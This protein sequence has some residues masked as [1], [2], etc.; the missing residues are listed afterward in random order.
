MPP[1]RL[2]IWPDRFWFST[3]SL[4]TGPSRR[5][6]VTILYALS[7]RAIR[8]ECSN[9]TRIESPA[10]LV[11][12]NVERTLDASDCE[13]L[14]FNL[15]PTS[16]EYHALS[17]MLNRTEASSLNVE[18]FESLRPRLCDFYAGQTAGGEAY[19]LF[20]EFVRAIGVYRPPNLVVDLRVLHV[21]HR[22]MAE[23]PLTHTVA[24][25]ATN[26]GISSDHLRHL[27]AKNL[28]VSLKSYM[29]WAKMRRAALL[30]PTGAS[31]TDVAQSVGFADSAHLSRTFKAYF[32]LMPSFLSDPRYVQVV[33]C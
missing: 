4:S 19:R 27:F 10:I 30:F 26:V 18:S 6:A 11:G 13:L 28:G 32:G 23:L 22:V 24:E 12:P 1:I 8:L 5:H 2:Y 31:L 21:A 9:G 3:P 15:D 33:D 20:N 17:R 14:S 16:Y 29:L 25:L 7:G